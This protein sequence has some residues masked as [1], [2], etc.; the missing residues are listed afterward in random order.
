[1]KFFSFSLH[2]SNI[3]ITVY[4]GFISTKRAKYS[5][6]DFAYLSLCQEKMLFLSHKYSKKRHFIKIH[7]QRS[8][9]ISWEVSQKEQKIFLVI[10]DSKEMENQKFFVFFSISSK[11]FFF[12]L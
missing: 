2:S 3:L 6:N 8:I 11:K 5:S 10:L 12:I 4:Y 1:L 9:Q 7:L